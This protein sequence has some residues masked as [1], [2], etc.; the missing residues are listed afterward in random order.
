MLALGETCKSVDNFSLSM[1]LGIV[2]LF[3]VTLSLVLGVCCCFVSSLSW[4]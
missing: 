1:A 4:L 2:A 3:F